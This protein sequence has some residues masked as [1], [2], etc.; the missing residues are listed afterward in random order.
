MHLGGRLTTGRH[1]ELDLHPVDD[2]G[3][4]GVGDGDGRHDHRHLPGRGVLAQ[5]AADLPVGAPRQRGAVHVAGAAQHRGA[6]VDVLGHHMVDEALRG[7]DGDPAG[8]DI[9]LRGD[10]QHAPEMIDVAVGV[11]DRGDGAL[12][13]AVPAIE[14]QR[15]GGD[16]GGDQR[17]DD[18]DAGV[19][20]DEG[21]VGD[22]EATDLVDTVDDFVETLLGRQLGLP[23]Q[24]GMHRCRGLTGEKAV[25]V[26]IP[27]HA[28]VGGGDDTRLQR[29]DEPAVGVLEIRC[30]PERQRRQMCVVRGLDSRAD[31]PV[32]HGDQRATDVAG[33]VGVDAVSGAPD[34]CAAG[35]R[36]PVGGAVACACA[37]TF[38]VGLRA[39][40]VPVSLRAPAV[41]A[42]PQAPGVPADPR[43]PAGGAVLPAFPVRVAV[44]GSCAS[45]TPHP[46]QAN[47]AIGAAG[48]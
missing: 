26:V 32:L 15:G 33:A 17:I 6:G 43:E 11:D 37:L 28:A 10:A 2:M 22:V 48:R 44:R 9:G 13:A 14:R 27:H 5:A 34:A 38:P 46:G 23:P 8:V 25:A 1:L 20:L 39:P 3:L 45:P 31:R 40:V 42:G 4:T 18:D 35:L 47:P 36:R 12:T 21:D 7:D 19:A 41:P 30:V 29:G 24:G 16:L